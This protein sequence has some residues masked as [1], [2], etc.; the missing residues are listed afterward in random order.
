M[1]CPSRAKEVTDIP[2][3]HTGDFA[4]A[5]PADVGMVNLHRH[6]RMPPQS[7]RSLIELLGVKKCPTLV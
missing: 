1:L 3:D 6:R 2:I 5:V 7:M 4:L